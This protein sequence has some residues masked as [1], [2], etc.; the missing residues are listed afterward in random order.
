MEV[1]YRVPKETNVTVR[2]YDQANRLVAELAKNL[3]RIPD[4]AY[5]E[6]WD[7]RIWDGSTA[8]NGMYF[9]VIELSIGKKEVYPVY[10]KN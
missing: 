10:I 2:I 3:S 7:G 9:L 5:C 8:A 4:V 1:T 6:K